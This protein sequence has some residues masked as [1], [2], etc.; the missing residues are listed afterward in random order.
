MSLWVIPRVSAG[1]AIADSV[2]SPR[3]TIGVVGGTQQECTA[4]DGATVTANANVYVPEGDALA[5]IEW[6]LNDAPIGSGEQITQVLALGMNTLS[7]QLLTRSGAVASAS[8]AVTA[9]DTQAPSVSAAFIDARTGKPVML[10]TAAAISVFRRVRRMPAIL[11][12]WYRRCSARRLRM[13]V[14]SRSRFNGAW[15]ACP[16]RRCSCR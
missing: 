9:R 10:P 6:T 15:S 5:S 14:R 7:A 1:G 4:H 12:Q 3:V 13:V 16:C 11:R 2:L 8:S